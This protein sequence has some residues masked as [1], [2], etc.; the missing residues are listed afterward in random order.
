MITRS[1][2]V[3]RLSVPLG[4][5]YDKA[6]A[7][8]EDLVPMVPLDRFARLATWD[9]VVELVADIAP[10][11][12]MRYAQL[13]VSGLLAPVEPR[14]SA[15]EYLMGNH[16][17]AERMFR[18]DP[19]IALHAPLRVVIHSDDAGEAVFAIEQPST[20]FAG[21]GREAIALVGRE[22][23]HRVAGVIRALGADPPPRRARHTPAPG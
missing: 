8:F 5:A 20:L 11:G 2:Q 10:L 23:D 3:T 6:I 16:S 15:V 22:L 18:H 19:A 13:D 17:I 12:F 9:A 1:Y 14:W 21:Y 7:R 4:Q